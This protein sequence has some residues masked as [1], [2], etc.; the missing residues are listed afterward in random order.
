M[1]SSPEASAHSGSS[2]SEDEFD[3][4]GSSLKTEGK[5]VVKSDKP[6]DPDKLFSD[7]SEEEEQA[8]D[9]KEVSSPKKESE[10]DKE[11]E[12]LFGSDYDSE[13]EEFKASY[14]HRAQCRRVWCG[15]LTVL[16]DYSEG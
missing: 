16:Y 15:S 14:V 1:A 4:G 9:K 12:D 2:S 11:M 3:L 10:K 13:E 8:D 7:D 6:A 5:A